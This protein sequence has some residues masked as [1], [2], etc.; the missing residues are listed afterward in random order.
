M[1][2]IT[3]QYYG[4]SFS[5]KVHC[6]RRSVSGKRT[7]DG[8]QFASAIRKVHVGYPEVCGT[9]RGDCGKQQAI[10]PVPKP[11]RLWRFRQG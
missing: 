8:I 9:E 4:S 10:F 3:Y 7:H 6:E 2:Q 11:V 5:N 1:K